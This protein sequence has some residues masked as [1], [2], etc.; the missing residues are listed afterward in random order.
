[1]VVLETNT[2]KLFVQITFP[3]IFEILEN[4]HFP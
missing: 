2:W 1:M 3:D 4:N